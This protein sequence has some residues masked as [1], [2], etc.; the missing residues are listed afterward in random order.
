MSTIRVDNFQPADGLTPAFPTGGISKASVAYD[1][2]TP[3][4]LRSSNLSSMTDHGAGDAAANFTNAFDAV[5]YA[6]TGAALNT[7]GTDKAFVGYDTGMTTAPA[8]SACG[9]AGMNSSGV[10][11]D[12][13]WINGS[14]MGDLA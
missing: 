5:D 10:R 13:D 1:H 9:I 6:F 7:S 4:T 3:A 12:Y 2:P 8:T 14:W 11:A